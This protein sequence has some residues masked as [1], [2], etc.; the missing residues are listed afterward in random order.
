[1]L[2]ILEEKGRFSKASYREVAPYFGLEPGRKGFDMET[3]HL[4]PV[5]IPMELFDTI[6]YAVGLYQSQYGLLKDIFNET[7][8]Q[9]F[10]SNVCPTTQTS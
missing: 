5:Y 2:I 1:L 6:L 3:F 7:G 4:R 8:V 9:H 10:F